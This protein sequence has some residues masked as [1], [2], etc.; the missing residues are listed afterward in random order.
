MPSGARL[1]VPSSTG[2]RPPRARVHHPVPTAAV[3]A[4]VASPRPGAAAV[5][6]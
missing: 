2:I 1:T 4:Q 6:T 3:D 5:A